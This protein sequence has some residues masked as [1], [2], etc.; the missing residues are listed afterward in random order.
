MV[1]VCG[2]C[3]FCHLALDS[4][5]KPIS[6]MNEG[7]GHTRKE[8]VQHVRVAPGAGAVGLEVRDVIVPGREYKM[9]KCLSWGVVLK[10]VH[11]EG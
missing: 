2:S 3:T 4:K 11:E 1:V 6:E 5:L 10:I 8:A 7:M 9:L